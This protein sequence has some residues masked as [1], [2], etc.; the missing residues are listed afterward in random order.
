MTRNERAAQLWSVLTLAARQ[1][2]ILSY[3]VAG[4]LT[5]L[6][7]FAVGDNLIP[8]QNY[9]IQNGLPPLTALVVSEKTGLPSEGFIAAQDVLPP[10][11][12]FMFMTGF[13]ARRRHQKISSRRH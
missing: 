10:R 1:Q 4:K 6:P 11:L 5:G 2:I 8:I 9:C 3:D 13:H 7:Q 12:A